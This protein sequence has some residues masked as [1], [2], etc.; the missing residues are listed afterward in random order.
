MRDAVAAGEALYD[1]ECASCHSAGDH[2]TTGF[3]GDLAGQGNNVISDLG[4]IDSAMSSITLTD[5]QVS[6]L[7]AFLDSL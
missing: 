4:S 1:A 2:D 6:D 7:M 3:A 5:Q